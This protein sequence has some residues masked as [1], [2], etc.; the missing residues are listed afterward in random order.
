MDSKMERGGKGRVKAGLLGGTWE[1][2][3][4]RTTTGN[5]ETEP[6][7]HTP[8]SQLVRHGME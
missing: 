4:W 2:C 5:S 8:A 3:K 6:P 1:S 7:R